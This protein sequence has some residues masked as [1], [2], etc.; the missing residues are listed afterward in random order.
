[1]VTLHE[2]LSLR[3]IYQ[4]KMTV[5]SLRD[6]GHYT[7]RHG[8]TPYRHS[9]YP[10]L[11]GESFL[12]SSLYPKF[13]LSVDQMITQFTSNMSH[14]LLS[15]SA[16]AKNDPRSEPDHSWNLKK[17]FLNLSTVKWIC[18]IQYTY[19]LCRIN[20]TYLCTYISWRGTVYVHNH[21]HT[22]AQIL[23]TKASSQNFLWGFCRG[24]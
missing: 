21:L 1:M 12:T 14:F 17:R 11:L 15:T 5:T 3:M 20:S 4:S 23:K 10:W 6:H 7:I 2:R 24:S 13:M 16:A 19:E 18:R 22:V 9:T 8:C